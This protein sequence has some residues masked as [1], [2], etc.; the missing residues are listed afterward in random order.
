MPKTKRPSKRPKEEEEDNEVFHVEKILQKRTNSDGSVDYFL[1]WKGYPDEENTWEPVEN[2]NCPLLISAFEK[3][4]SS[5]QNKSASSGQAS[6]STKSK[7]TPKATPK[8]KSKKKVLKDKVL[9]GTFKVNGEDVDES[10][11][12]II[13][14]PSGFKKGWEPLEVLGATEDNGQILFLIKWKHG[15]SSLV[16]ATEANKLIPQMVIKFYESKLAWEDPS[17]TT[18]ADV[19][20]EP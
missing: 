3:T 8:E 12:D 17:E 4:L 11:F 19:E 15:H 20:M 2:L 1:K 5:T 10:T 9:K 16:Y 6:S 13:E 14:E 7:G 18:N